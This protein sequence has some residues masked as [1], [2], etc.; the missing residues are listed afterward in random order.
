MSEDVKEG[1]I[2]MEGAGISPEEAVPPRETEAGRVSA[3]V[4][5][6]PPAVDKFEE[7]RTFIQ[8]TEK[9]TDRRQLATQIWVTLHTLLFAALGFLMKETGASLLSSGGR[10]PAP[11]A[12]GEP[13]I[14][15]LSIGPL[16][17]I[18]IFSCVIWRKM[19]LSYRSLI[20]WRFDQL[21]EMER[22]AELAGLQRVFNREWK[23]FFGPDAREQI[24][25][26]RLEA[27]LPAVLIFVYLAFGVV[28]T[29][30]GL[31]T[32]PL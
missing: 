31:G 24:G 1:K 17:L 25:F 8:S 12:A 28:A 21:M 19:L 3:P 4:V 18:G 9:L 5:P 14:F 13:W 23:H 10:S 27:L 6:S 2:P 22:S 11:A 16:V 7:Y 15:L 26:T 29:L 20:G 32:I 30:I